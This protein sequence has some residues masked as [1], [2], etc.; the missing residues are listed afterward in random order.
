[1]KLT[2]KQ[3]F[4]ALQRAEKQR[5]DTLKKT[6]AHAKESLEPVYSTD[7]SE[8]ARLKQHSC[9]RNGYGAATRAMLNLNSLF[10]GCS[11][12][13]EIPPEIEKSIKPFVTEP[14]QDNARDERGKWAF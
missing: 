11:H 14:V 10:V 8:I 13:V 4:E 12:E 3:L 7:K 1:M 6:L 9:L 2:V 5:Q